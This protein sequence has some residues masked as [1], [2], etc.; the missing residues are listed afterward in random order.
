LYLDRQLTARCRS[1]GTKPAFASILRVLCSSRSKTTAW[2]PESSQKN[3]TTQS[4]QATLAR[5]TQSSQLIESTSTD[6]SELPDAELLV[7]VIEGKFCTNFAPFFVA[8]L[9]ML[10]YIFNTARS[11]LHS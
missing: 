2:A 1:V 6:A 3:E 4:S 10:F 8:M 9:L 5:I 7:A 11:L